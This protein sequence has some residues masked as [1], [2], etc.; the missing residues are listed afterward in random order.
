VKIPSERNQPEFSFGK[1]WLESMIADCLIDTGAVAPRHFA[2]S[3][4]PCQ[5]SPTVNHSDFETYRIEGRR[6]FRIVPSRRP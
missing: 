6:K 4:F 1:I 5:Y 2:I 3:A